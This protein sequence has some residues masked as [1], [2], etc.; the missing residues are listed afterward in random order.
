M[1]NKVEKKV[2]DLQQK[3]TE[4][5]QR[6]YNQFSNFLSLFGYK[7]NLL[8]Y[9]QTTKTNLKQLQRRL[10][11][12]GIEYSSL[13][14]K[15]YKNLVDFKPKD[16][17]IFKQKS[18][19]TLSTRK[20]RATNEF[21]GTVHVAVNNNP[22]QMFPHQ[23]KAIQNLDQIAKTKKSFRGMLVLPTG[24]GKTFTAIY[25]LLKNFIS[26]NK[27]VLWIAHRHALLSQTAQ[28]VKSSAY[29]NILQD[30]KNFKYRIVSG[31]HDKM[32]HI[33][34]SDDII[35][36]S[37]DSISSSLP[38]LT[39]QWLNKID[40]VILVI[41]EA[42]HATAKTYRKIISTLNDNKRLKSLKILGLTATPFRTQDNEKGLLRKIFKDDIVYKIDLQTLISKG[43]LSEPIF[44]ELDT[45]FKILKLKGIDK[46]TL[47][48]IRHFDIGALGKEIT[49]KIAENK[50]RN[51]FIV[52][53]YS[54][55]KGKYGQ[56]IVFAL[57]VVN[58][59]ALSTLFVK[60][61]I[62]ADY[63]VSGI[64]DMATHINLSPE[65]NAKKIEQFKN[66]ELQVLINVNI[67][68]EGTDIPHVKTI[69]LTRPTISRILM[70]QMIG[71]GL[72]GKAVGGTE[73]AYIVSF[74]DDWQNRLTW[75]N[76]EKLFVSEKVRFAENSTQRNPMVARLVELVA[77]EKIKEFVLFFDETSDT[78]GLEKYSFKQRLPLGVYSFTIKDGDLTNPNEDA[79]D[80]N[81]EILVYNSNSKQYH[82]FVTSLKDYFKKLKISSDREQFTDTQL[83]KLSASV[84]SDFFADVDDVLGGDLNKNVSNILQYYMINETEPEFLLFADRDKYDISKIAAE[85]IDTDLGERSKKELIDREWLNNKSAWQAFFSC[86][87]DYFQNQIQREI[88]F[89]LH[90][91]EPPTAQALP[92]TIT[93]K[94]PLEKLTLYQ[95]SEKDQEYGDYLKQ[96]IYANAR[97]KDGYYHCAQSNFKNKKKQHFHIDH[98]VPMSK[99]GLTQLANLQLL[100][101]K[102][103]WQKSNK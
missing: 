94:L 25:W 2:L 37:K 14:E 92:T 55:N 74:I 28:T 103:N 88:N 12:A 16:P 76:P 45:K 99:G 60:Q 40:E 50:K 15:N 83:S 29:A 93:E 70:T 85:I 65:E 100:E 87:K 42:H 9:N 24:G 79:F 3:I 95:I 33:R 97:D 53:K 41:D 36:A 43:I 75:V 26:K 32:I 23:K 18:K 54:K 20:K 1:K 86:N 67:L 81:C 31:I 98:I 49:K 13:N 84:I 44:E 4:Q 47:E 90:D 80:R 51:K 61:G 71:R 102:K 72:R 27:K 101:R 30:R 35:I 10:K 64:R 96:T 58:A 19:E 22:R 21:A 48:K 62:K 78:K 17:I 7:R 68:T 11:K 66:K 8:G 69:F 91:D 46:N 89:I 6:R 73:K 82:K 57:D 63:I 5:G 52:E 77:I 34:P 38:Q 39:K 59:I 56:T